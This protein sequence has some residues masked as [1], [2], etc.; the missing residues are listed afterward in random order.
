MSPINT[1][2][3]RMYISSLP[4]TNMATY[5]LWWNLQANVLSCLHT[6]DW[7]QKV[8]S[9][10]TKKI[11]VHTHQVHLIQIHY[12]SNPGTCMFSPFI[13]THTNLVSAWLLLVVQRKLQSMFVS[14]FL[15]L[16]LNSVTNRP[17]LKKTRQT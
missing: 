14:A 5:K 15:S 1:G 6:Q 10:S 3:Y 12:E 17:V 16:L 7:H 8:L 2:F 13:T 4:H 9:G 11:M